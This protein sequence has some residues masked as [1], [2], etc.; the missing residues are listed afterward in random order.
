MARGV[1][2]GEG[3][4]TLYNGEPGAD[5]RRRRVMDGLVAVLCS[6]SNHPSETVQFHICKVGMISEIHA[7]GWG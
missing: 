4:D 6:C 2:D 7:G 3:E 1:L 5:E